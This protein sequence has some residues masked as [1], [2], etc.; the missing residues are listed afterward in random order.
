MKLSIFFS[1][2]LAG[3]NAF[4]APGFYFQSKPVVSYADGSALFDALKASN[5]TDEEVDVCY[6]GD[7]SDAMSATEKLV[8]GAINFSLVDVYGE[9]EFPSLD[10]EFSNDKGDSAYGIISSCN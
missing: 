5:E 7:F 1:V 9:D 4:A 2:L 10:L 6:E 3:I 8:K